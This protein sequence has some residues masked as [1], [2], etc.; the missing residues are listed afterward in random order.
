LLADARF[1]MRD[2]QF[3]IALSALQ[4]YHSGVVSMPECALRRQATGYS[5][6]RL[7]S[8]RDDEWQTKTMILEGHTH[9]VRS[10]AFSSDG[11]RIVSGSYDCTVRIWDAA[12]GV[13]LHTLGGHTDSVRSAAFSS[14]GSRI[15][16]GSDDCTVCIWDAVLGVVQHTLEGHTEMVHSVAFSLDGLRIVSGS[17]D[18]TVCIWDAGTGEIQN[19]LQDYNGRNVIQCFL[20]GSLLCKGLCTSSKRSSHC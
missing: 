14:D 5:T 3:P 20:A 11:S 7:I 2:Y 18:H 15:V 12:L 4:V 16:S 10:V 8:E 13:V 19:I 17:D 6:V 9:W 1:F